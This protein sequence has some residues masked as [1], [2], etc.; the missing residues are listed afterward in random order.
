LRAAEGLEAE[1]V[2][3]APELERK[4]DLRVVVLDAAADFSAEAED[5]LAR[6]ARSARLVVRNKSD[7]V[8]A[9]SGRN[10]DAAVAT[11]ADAL[12]VSARTGAGV[13]GLRE[14]IARRLLEG[15]GREP[16]D[17]VLPSERHEEAIR[18]AIASLDAARE[19]WADGWTEEMLAGDVRDAA[20]ALGEIT[21]RT[22]GE[23][24]LDRIFSKFCI[25][26]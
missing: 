11:I 1:G 8:A 25:G 4:A 13:A 14:E 16:A 17:E 9:G 7:L 20:A 10:G 15:V 23:E 24:V 26:K 21:G 2:R 3:R 5:V 22:V 12:A 19:S 6:T 18:R